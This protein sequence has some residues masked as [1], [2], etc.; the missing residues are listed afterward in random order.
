MD[1]EKLHY[2]DTL[3]NVNIY[4]QGKAGT[5]TEKYISHLLSGKYKKYEETIERLQKYTKHPIDVNIVLEID[6]HLGDVK[7]STKAQK[8]FNKTRRFVRNTK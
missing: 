6:S 1:E 2:V 5:T 7:G 8:I 3:G 4:R